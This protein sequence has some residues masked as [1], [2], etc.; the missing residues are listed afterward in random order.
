MSAHEAG[1]LSRR[2]HRK[3]RLGC[4]NCKRR[5][6]KCDEIQPACGNCKRH[7]IECDYQIDP[8]A[9]KASNTP[10]ERSAS[11]GECPPKRGC[12]FFSSYQTNFKPPKRPH[13]RRKSMLKAIQHMSTKSVISPPLPTRPFDFT[14][15]D[16]ELFHYFL[17][18]EDLGNPDRGS[19]QALD[20]VQLPR[21]GFSFP[22]VLRLLLTLSGFHRLRHRMDTPG[23][24][25]LLQQKD[26]QVTA[27]R[28]YS[29]AVRELS[30]ALPRLEKDNSY[31]IFTAAA[32]IFICGFARGP[33]EG[34]YL[35]FREDN[36]KGFLNLFMGARMVATTCA[37]MFP[38]SAAGGQTESSQSSSEQSKTKDPTTTRRVI[39]DYEAQLNQL[40]DLAFEMDDGL[41]PPVYSVIISRLHQLYD[42][43]YS[44]HPPTHAELWPLV[45]AWLYQLPDP[46][47]MGLQHRDPVSLVIF[48]HFAVLLNELS[49]S[50]LIR[51]WPEHILA[52]I[53]RHLDDYHRPF[54]QWPIA[55]IL[56]E[57]VN[58]DP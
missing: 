5:R 12:T 56:R 28:H 8:N 26:Y 37:M 49:F 7:S 16:M 15:I 13:R 41:R 9:N 30:A 55:H 35:A 14:I 2:P 18:T 44:T 19:G 22:Y 17:T 6:V 29:L 51:G 40:Q 24:L 48:A 45:F 11:A 33:Q 32:N 3:S 57:S 43:I 25:C 10:P 27:E 47:L 58:I 21:L 38:S 52:G 50:W 53:H 34:E 31:A 39:S 23:Q 20:R 1:K 4:G 54:I 36:E 42:T 46:F